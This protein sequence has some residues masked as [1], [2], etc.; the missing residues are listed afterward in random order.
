[1]SDF[2]LY[3][4]FRSSTSY[5]VRIA[6]NYKQVDFEYRAVHLLKNGG[7]QNSPTYLSLNPQAEVPTL[8]YKNG[9]SI[10][11]SVAIVEYLDEILP[12]PPLFP[13]DPFL[14]AKVRQFCENIKSYL[15]PLANHKVLQK[16]E[17]EYGFTQ[18]QKNLWVQSWSTKGFEALEKI[19]QEFSGDFCFGNS[20]TA[21][22]VFLVP[23]LFTAKRFQVDTARYQLCSKIEERCLK[24]KIFEKA[25]PYRQPDTPENEKI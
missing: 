17:N 2:V 8:L 11:Q 3:N 13:Q 1:M 7:E 9:K 5:R 25:H 19:L 22:D 21:A 16:L 24:M 20:L 23:A 14:R 10:S 4:Y 12:N 6:L 15:H 18:E